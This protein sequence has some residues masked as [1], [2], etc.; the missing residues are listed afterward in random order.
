MI[1]GLVEPGDATSQVYQR[2]IAR[3]QR[4]AEV[5]PDS[6]FGWVLD[7]NAVKACGHFVRGGG[8]ANTVDDA[9]W[10]VF[11]AYDKRAIGILTEHRAV[12][13]R[14]TSWHA[15]MIVAGRNEGWPI[16][17]IRRVFD[18]GVAVDPMDYRLYHYMEDALQPQW[19]GDPAVLDAFVRDV[20]TKAPPALGMALYAR[21]YSGVEETQFP[22]T[23]YRDSLVD[24][25]MMKAGLE[26]WTA[27]FPTSWNRNIFAY[28]ACLAADRPA[29]KALFAQIGA[30][31]EAEIWASDRGDLFAACSRWAAH[32][33]AGAHSPI[34]PPRARTVPRRAGVVATAAH[35][36]AD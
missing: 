12:A 26:A 22:L 11:H 36:P 18:E 9:A 23:L 16:D 10:A 21:L 27:H 4:W 2:D 13:S 14:T 25:P 30:Q 7:A 24:W 20:S 28:H 15:M 32:P 19:L 3:T 34:G 29:A 31:R 35:A 17:D 33:E 5:H 8:Y 1:D 6:A